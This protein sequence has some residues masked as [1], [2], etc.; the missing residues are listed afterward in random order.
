[1]VDEGSAKILTMKPYDSQ[2]RNAT[3]MFIRE[4]VENLFCVLVNQLS[5]QEK[6]G[7]KISQDS[8][9][10]KFTKESNISNERAQP[11]TEKVEIEI[12]F[13][14][15]GDQLV[16]IQFRRKAGSSIL[17]KKKVAKLREAFVKSLDLKRH[18]GQF[19][20]REESH[21]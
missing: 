7:F 11:L 1:M 12:E 13:L 16:S 4:P 19:L 2:T 3:D 6:S 15:A 9:K 18:T 17:F 5:G 20:I 8:W 10:F 14:D 21:E